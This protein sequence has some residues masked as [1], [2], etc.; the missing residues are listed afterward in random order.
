MGLLMDFLQ[1][2]MIDG[3]GAYCRE[4]GLR[5]DARW[6]VRADWMPTRPNWSGV[7]AHLIDMEVAYERAMALG[8]PIVYLS[9]YLGQRV[10]P[11]V[12]CDFGECGAMASR[13]FGRMG[14]KKVVGLKGPQT[15]VECRAMRGFRVEA[16][17]ANMTC[18][19][20]EG[21]Q[22]GRDWLEKLDE[23]AERLSKLT[24]PIGLF[25]VNAGT[26][27][28]LMDFL[29]SRGVRV[30]GEVAMIVIDKDPQRTSELAPV[31]LTAVVPDF[32][33]QGYQAAGIL[34]QMMT[35]EW[36]ERGIKRVPPLRLVRRESTGGF[37]TK[38]PLVGKAMHILEG[39]RGQ[40][41]G[42]DELAA[43]VGVSRRT[44]EMRFRS[45]FGMTP[46]AAQLRFRIEEAKL[47]LVSSKV[48]IDQIA[49][50]AGFS[51]VHYFGSVFKRVVG[52]TPGAY[53]KAEG[54]ARR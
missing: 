5:L 52:K 20:W 32:W 25:L 26:A 41:M 37:S 48:A 30:P 28:S 34:D 2:S 11:R 27:V 35:G 33:R 18:E 42:I 13:E 53:R 40:F 7:L 49:R 21:Q 6:S 44:V 1:P 29:M 43:M 24:F 12:D 8:L 31:P 38:D 17:R 3:A 23:V 46:N 14:M 9:G 51:S 47:L 45:E 22:K 50:E 36:H 10:L 4:N 54:E 39:S 19:V 16:A 15:G